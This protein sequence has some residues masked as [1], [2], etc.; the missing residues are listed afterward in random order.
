M[1]KKTEKRAV[2]EDGIQRFMQIVLSLVEAF[3]VDLEDDVYH[4]VI[5]LQKSVERHIFNQ[6][7]SGVSRNTKEKRKVRQ[8]IAIFKQRFLQLVDCEYGDK[9]SPIDGRL[10]KSVIEKVEEA[11]LTVEGYLQWTF[12][13]FL[14]NNPKFIPPNIRQ[15]CANH[16]VVSFIYEKRGELKEARERGIEEKDIVDLANRARALLKSSSISE[17]AK[18]NLKKSLKKTRGGDIILEELRAEIERLESN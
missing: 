13:D 1:S 18:N 4:Y 16:F 2:P 14:P 7:H 12:D 17:D 6:R 10:I 9:S 5:L 11:G 15:I 8:F 3:G